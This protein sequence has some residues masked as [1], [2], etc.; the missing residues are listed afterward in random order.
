[1]N[2][3]D[4]RQA[5]LPAQLLDEAPVADGVDDGVVALCG[6]GRGAGGRVVLLVNGGQ[7][8]GRV[9]GAM[10]VVVFLADVGVVVGGV[11][12]VTEDDL[13]DEA[14]ED[15]DDDAGLESLA[16]DDEEDRNAEQ[17]ACHCGE[18]SSRR[19]REGVL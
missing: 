7:V 17:V 8:C 9:V 18:A 16:E 6:S 5:D 15:G 1:M 2:K 19:A 3:G 10:R 12:V 14:E 13:L 4:G 11:G